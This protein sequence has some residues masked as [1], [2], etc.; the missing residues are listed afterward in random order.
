MRAQAEACGYILTFSVRRS[1][2]KIPAGHCCPA[3]PLGKGGKKPALNSFIVLFSKPF[4]LSRLGPSKKSAEEDTTYS[5]YGS[6]VHIPE[7]LAKVAFVVILTGKHLWPSKAWRQRAFPSSAWEREKPGCSLT[8]AAAYSPLYQMGDRG[9]FF[10]PRAG[11]D[12][13]LDGS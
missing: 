10:I 7:P 9:G 3:P 1:T 6:K 11:P 4:P 2:C 5:I 13:A 12:P 8:L